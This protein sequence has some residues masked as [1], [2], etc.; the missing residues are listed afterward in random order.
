MKDWIVE[1]RVT[2][3]RVYLVQA[4]DEKEAI[5][6]S[7]HMPPDS[8]EDEYEETMSVVENLPY[9]PTT[10][11]FDEPFRHVDR[12]T[13]NMGSWKTQVQGDQVSVSLDHYSAL[14]RDHQKLTALEAGTP[15]VCSDCPQIGYP[16]DKTRCGPCPRRLPGSPASPMRGQS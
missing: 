12:P 16:T 6:F 14:I 15:S 11:P 4:E 10:Q 5:F 1:T 9:D 8:D 7:T 2:S 13:K 3:R